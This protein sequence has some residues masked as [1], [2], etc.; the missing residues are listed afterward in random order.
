MQFKNVC[1]DIT[2]G[3]S[4]IGKKLLHIEKVPHEDNEASRDIEKNLV[5]VDSASRE[6]SEDP[7]EHLFSLHDMHQEKKDVVFSIPEVHPPSILYTFSAFVQKKQALVLKQRLFV[8][9]Q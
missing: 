2:K 8:L 6:L 1:A 4:D 5:H 7:F 3:I 9:H